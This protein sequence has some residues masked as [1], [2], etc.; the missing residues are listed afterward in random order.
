MPS[1]EGIHWSLVLP[2]IE[3]D[4]NM[5]FQ[6]EESQEVIF[7]TQE[8][9]AVIAKHVRSLISNIPGAVFSVRI[10]RQWANAK[11]ANEPRSIIYVEGAI[12]FWEYEATDEAY[13][14]SELL[15]QG[16]LKDIAEEYQLE[17]NEYLKH[18]RYHLVQ[19]H[20]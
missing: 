19:H 2:E 7:N 1:T 11:V 12:K 16:I 14:K 5:K 3:G 17:L 18:M 6:V 13:R 15:L 20:Q 4:D 8:D 10:N 9:I